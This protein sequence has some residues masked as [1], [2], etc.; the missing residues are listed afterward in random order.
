MAVK[1]SYDKNITESAE[2]W[3]VKFASVICNKPPKNSM[4][5]KKGTIFGNFLLIN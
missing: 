5:T 4:L 3:L 2:L 1:Q